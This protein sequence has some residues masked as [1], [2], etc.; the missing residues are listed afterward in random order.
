MNVC[1]FQIYGLDQPWTGDGQQMKILRENLIRYKNDKTKV[2]LVTN[3][4]N[5]IFNQGPEFVLDKFETL[6]PARIVFGAEDICWPD[7][8]LQVTIDRLIFYIFLNFVIQYDYPFV[9]SNEKR[10]LNSE[11]FMGYASDIYEMISSQDEIKDKQLF[12]TKIFLDE[13]TR[14]KEE[15]K[16]YLK[17]FN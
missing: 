4:Y 3:A 14:V 5:V 6:K 12:F 9:G 11:G 7:E 1:Y 17:Y 13:T 2:L 15:N 8:K 10:F 16:I